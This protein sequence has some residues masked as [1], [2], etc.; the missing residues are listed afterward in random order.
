MLLTAHFF[1][2][3]STMVEQSGCT[4]DG[5]CCSTTA[6]AIRLPATASCRGSSDLANLGTAGL[7]QRASTPLAAGCTAGFGVHLSDDT[8]EESSAQSWCQSTKGS[9]NPLSQ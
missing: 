9:P 4:V 1:A 8:H 5:S 6:R 7:V 2:A 3:L